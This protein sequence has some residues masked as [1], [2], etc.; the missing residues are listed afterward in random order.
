MRH[1]TRLRYD[2]V[3]VSISTL[4]PCATKIGSPISTPVANSFLSVYAELPSLGRVNTDA[5]FSVKLNI[6]LVDLPTISL[7]SFIVE[8]L[9]KLLCLVPLARER[10]LLEVLSEDDRE[11]LIRLLRCLHENLPAVELATQSYIAES[12]AQPAKKSQRPPQP[13]RN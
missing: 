4:S 13:R 11:T 1:Q 3:R 12:L 9:L 10:A 2:P 8:S 5:I 6:Q 7:V